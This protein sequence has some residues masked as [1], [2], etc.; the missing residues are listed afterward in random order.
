MALYFCYI[1]QADRDVPHMR[2]VSCDKDAVP[3]EVAV[4]RR[5]W[6][7]AT[8]IEVFEDDR[9]IWTTPVVEVAQA[10]GRPSA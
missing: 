5:Q 7:A 4:L 3:G 6:P 2:A 10:Q 8:R 1:H 9:L